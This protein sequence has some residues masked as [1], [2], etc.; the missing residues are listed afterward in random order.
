MINLNQ[1]KKEIRRQINKITEDD[2]K[3]GDYNFWCGDYK[4]ISISANFIFKI[5]NKED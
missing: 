2:I 5:I 1:I 3:V 4:T